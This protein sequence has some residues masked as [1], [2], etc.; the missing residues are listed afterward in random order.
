M[1]GVAYCEP[2]V[3]VDGL[4]PGATMRRSIMKWSGAVVAAAGVFGLLAAALPAEALAAREPATFVY[5][6][7]DPGDIT[8]RGLTYVAA[9]PS[10]TMS[11]QGSKVAPDLLVLVQ[12]HGREFS[13][14]VDRDSPD[15]VTT[16]VHEFGAGDPSGYAFSATLPLGQGAGLRGTLDIRQLEF[17]K[18]GLDVKR[19]DLVFSGYDPEWGSGGVEGHVAY[20]SP[21]SVDLPRSPAVLPSGGSLSN[22][23]QLVNQSGVAGGL[24]HG[25]TAQRLT[26][27]GDGQAV[28]LRRDFP[29]PGDDFVDAV[30]WLSPTAGSGADRLVLSGSGRLSLRAGADKVVWSVRPKGAGKGTFLVVNYDGRLLLVSARFKELWSVG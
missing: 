6:K 21:K 12:D 16:G 9:A 11:V 17:T 8:G 14:L 27:G 1:I 18:N 7:S 28:L 30:T 20:R 4:T 24:E 15:R 29:G 23:R 3:G 26:L 13:F 10:V 22:R 25:D 5:V 2:P 19:L